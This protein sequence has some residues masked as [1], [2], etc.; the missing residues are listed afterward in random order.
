MRAIKRAFDPLE[1][2]NPGKGFDARF[3]GPGYAH[4]RTSA[5]QQKWRRKVM[6]SLGTI[7][8][9]RFHGYGC[10]YGAQYALGQ[11]S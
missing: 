6:V 10:G 11:L 5:L 7:L 2:M 1:I 4:Y 3:F 9:K 8:A